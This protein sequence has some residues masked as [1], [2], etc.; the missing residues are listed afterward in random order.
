MTRGQSLQSD[1]GSEFYFYM[2]LVDSFLDVG[3]LLL[4][5]YIY[6]VVLLSLYLLVLD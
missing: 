5:L 6:I 4:E 3:N 2:L 1:L